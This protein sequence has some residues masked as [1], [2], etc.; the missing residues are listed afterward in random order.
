MTNAIG[1]STSAAAAA[2]ATSTSGTTAPAVNEQQFMQLLIAQLQHQDPTQPVQGTEF[3]T[4]LAQF[5]LVEQS[6]NQTTQLTSLNTQMSGLTN[7]QTSQLIGQTVTLN[8]NSLSFDGTVA[9]PA[10]A[11]LSGAAAQVTATISDSSGNLVR[12][13]NLGPHAAGPI[14]IPWNGL[15][16]SGLT[17]P[18]GSYSV[19]VAATDS[20][21]GAVGVSQNV[22]GVVANV[23][24]VSGSPQLTLTSG[25]T[26]P[27]SNVMSVGNPTSP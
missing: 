20:S 13:M 6:A 8:G 26:A 23:S 12:T 10:N 21:G 3:V 7:D 17:Q 22:T 27:V 24:F 18:S 2:A 14:T 9:T 1:Q 5:S 16:N 15:N 19:S 4:Q 25:A 11:T